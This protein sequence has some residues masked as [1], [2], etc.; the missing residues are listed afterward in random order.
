MTTDE[1][2]VS[3]IQGGTL[4]DYFAA[5]FLMRIDVIGYDG[6]PSPE[7]E[8]LAKAAYKVADAMLKERSRRTGDAVPETGLHD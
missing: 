2:I 8:L 6:E 7:P 4:R 1:R 3:T 5:A